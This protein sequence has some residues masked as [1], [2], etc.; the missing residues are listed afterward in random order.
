MPTSV[1]PERCNTQP[2]ALSG[3]NAASKG[4]RSEPESKGNPIADTLARLTLGEP[5][6]HKNLTLFP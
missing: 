4:H 2:F 6:H 5:A 3:A 1:R